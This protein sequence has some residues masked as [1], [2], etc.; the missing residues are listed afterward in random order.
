MEN[1][2][3]FLKNEEENYKTKVLKKGIFWLETEYLAFNLAIKENVQ[4]LE[5]A[6]QKYMNNEINKSAFE[7]R[8]ND[9]KQHINHWQNMIKIVVDELL[10]RSE[11]DDIN[12]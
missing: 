4:W 11:T 5:D 3:T 9:E 8:I 7:Y 6:Y 1:L 12:I 2:E 10:K